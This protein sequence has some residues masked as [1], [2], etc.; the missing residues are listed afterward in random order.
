M[1]G[2]AAVDLTVMNS[3]VFTPVDKNPPWPPFAKG[4]KRHASPFIKYQR[5]I[6]GDFHYKSA[7]SA[8][9]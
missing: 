1:E 7:G 6:E 3:V 8:V 4:G 5:G 9:D 2:G